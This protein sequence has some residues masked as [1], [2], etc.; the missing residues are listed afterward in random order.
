MQSAVET[1]P[2]VGLASSEAATRLAT[3]GPNEIT[4]S[5]GAPAWR[6]FVGQFASPLVLL[7][8]AAC[9]VS[10]ALGEVIDAAAIA[11]I[12]VLNGVIGFWQEYSAQNA[13]MALR[14]MT[15][16]RARVIRDGQLSVIP[17]R[18]VVPGDCLV[19][20]AGDMV[21][22]D[23]RLVEA[24]D[25]TTN[26]SALTGESQP[27][28]KGA[29][30]SAANAA[31][32]DR[33]DSVFLGTFVVNGTGSAEVVATG[34]GTE[35]GKIATLLEGVEDIATPLQEQLEQVGK[36]LLWI[37]LGIVAL[38]AVTGIVQ[39]QAWLDVLML[40]VP[41]AVAAIPEGLPA[42]VT[43]ALSIGVQRM[44]ARNVLVRRLPSVETLGSTTVI[45]TDKTGTLTTGA[46]AVRE[47]WGPDHVALLTAATSC[48]DAEL[49]SDGT[50][51]G[52]PTEIAIARA[53][54]ERGI[55]RATIEVENPRRE[56][57]PFD[58]E[59]K[60]MS[61]LRGDGRLYLKGAVD[62]LAPLCTSGVD[63]A[64]ATNAELAARGLRVMAVAV[65]NG[66][67]EANLQLL[68]LI[69]IADPPRSEA[70]EAIAAAR[71]AGIT[72]VM[73]TGDHP[74]TA[75]AI[76]REMGILEP[77]ED[78]AERV[79]ARATPEDKL[80]IVQSWKAK[81]AVV[82]M[83]GD[84]VNDA[85]ALREAH[86]GIAMGRGGTEVTREAADMVL[87]D[88]N[89]ASIIAAVRE[90]R[91]IWENIRKTVVYLLGGN[92]GELVTVLGATLLGLP[93]PLMPLHLLWINLATDGF[94]ALA[95]VTDPPAVD[96]LD[97]PPRVPGQAMLGRQEWTS[98]V[99]AGLLQ[100]G[101]VLGTFWWKFNTEGLDVARNLAFSVIVFVELFRAFA[102]RS[103]DRTFWQ[104]GALTNVRLVAVVLVSAT[105]QVGM[106]HVPAVQ[107][108]F[109]VAPLTM[110]D[111]ILSIGLGLIPVTLVEGAKLLPRRRRS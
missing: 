57:H 105:I 79:H 54:F 51:V 31:L 2:T 83:T 78:A 103:P 68:G 30:A 14:A 12:V 95:L 11:T 89:F 34:M 15:A 87:A 25:F 18:D 33:H 88:D 71:R 26:E 73:I 10:V 106:H 100:A 61:I 4:R 55:V 41:L 16:P 29:S 64:L 1:S 20:K 32:A 3:A 48:L 7:L 92:F 104:V 67:A 58:S 107:R 96:V 97:R 69:G 77:G 60:R 102:A 19:L 35:L 46:M 6:M 39:G 111:C 91:G 45:C 65:G 109:H 110:S 37:C 85:P 43:V 50:A 52:D 13:V 98:V 17:A 8:L 72:T 63:G 94:P 40:A 81:G 62:R 70:I 36:S 53:G 76:A 84:G 66:P 86:V 75:E 56:V 5:V 93:A 27:S 74:I 44:A 42:V 24:H 49:H 21:A 9:G 101:V 22:A 38:I 82:A 23:G 80:R 28:E 99:L 59:K 47:L 90:G 108:L